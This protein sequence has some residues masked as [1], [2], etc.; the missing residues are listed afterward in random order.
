[1]W[2]GRYPRRRLPRLTGC[3][4]SARIRRRFPRR[5]GAACASWVMKRMLSA[6]LFALISARIVLACEAHAQHLRSASRHH[7][8]IDA[9]LATCACLAALAQ[10]PQ[11]DV[12]YRRVSAGRGEPGLQIVPLLL[13][14]LLQPVVIGGQVELADSARDAVRCLMLISHSFSRSSWPTLPEAWNRRRCRLIDL[15]QHAVERFSRRCPD[16][17]AASSSVC[18]WR[19][20]SCS[21][22]DLRSA[23]LC[24]L[25]NLEQ[26]QQCDVVLQRPSFL[27]R[28]YSSRS[29]RSSSRNRVRTRSLSGILVADHE[30]QRFPPGPSRRGNCGQVFTQNGEK[31]KGLKYSP[32]AGK[33]RPVPE[34]GGGLP[35]KRRGTWRAAR[36]PAAQHASCR[37]HCGARRRRAPGA[38]RGSSAQP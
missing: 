38:A 21:R 36:S 31:N 7:L 33:N 4:T 28:K 1:M 5:S 30:G 18:F 2:A 20:S 24:H 32:K 22:S 8:L 15:P 9:L 3:R 37:R 23:R 13:G 10:Q 14:A 29:Y 19:S 34:P 6:Y 25:E 11:H 26:E 12:R 27:A 17:R 16:C 35:R